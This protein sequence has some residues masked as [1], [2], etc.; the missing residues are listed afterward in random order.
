MGGYY[1]SGATRGNIF[2]H[3]GDGLLDNIIFYKLGLTSRGFIKD[4]KCY[5]MSYYL[6][7][8]MWEGLA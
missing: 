6:S 5:L 1:R 8:M 3:D 4:M 7:R 2:T